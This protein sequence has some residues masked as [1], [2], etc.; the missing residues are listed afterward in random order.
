MINKFICPIYRLIL[1][2]I[3][4]VTLFAQSI[5]TLQVFLDMRT[6]LRE[7]WLNPANET[8]GLRGDAAPLSWGT[9]YPAID[10]DGDGIYSAIVTFEQITDSLKLNFK[11]KVDGVDNPNDGW[12]SGR[13][14][15][16]TIYHQRRNRLTLKWEDR[17]EA[18]AP[19][20]TGTIKVI[21]DYNCDP[22]LSRD[23]YI[24][25]PPGYNKTDLRYPVLY[26]HDGQSMFDAS[27]TGEEWQMDEAAQLLIK[28]KQIEPLIIVG[29]GNTKR[30]L[31]EYTPTRQ[32]WKH[33]LQRVSHS[34]SE[35]NLRNYAGTFVTESGDSVSFSSE[36]DT[37]FAQIPGSDF[38]QTL[39]RKSLNTFYLPRAGIT[40]RFNIG[41][42]GSIKKIIADK[43]PEGGEGNIYA[44]LI[45]NK[46]KPFIDKNF[47]T[48][49]GPQFTGLGGSSLGGLITLYIG[50]DHPDVFGSLLVVSPSIW[51]DN[52]WILKRTQQLSASTGQRIWLDIGTGEGKQA[53][54]NVRALKT[55]LIE[56]HWP[57]SK[58]KYME[59]KGARHNE[60]A[61]AKRVP[62]M[63]RFVFNKD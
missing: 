24:Y 60:K 26:M 53:V 54:N 4:P 31:D 38:L 57:A 40:F 30:R 63:L 58:F 13:N 59:V 37:L 21:K 46:I 52:K 16:V 51:W 45:I 42:D 48:K 35:G 56:K 29:I 47:R 20:I 19:T 34:V 23:I 32:V 5:D 6:P 41:P 2:L 14:H 36:N 33:T 43:I 18:P 50:L 10:N 39:I 49:K 15:E 61:W 62:E 17:A 25:L 55:V 28:Q 44:N 9:T 8:V 12:Q 7:G 27:I 3:F 22:L 1:L 11:I